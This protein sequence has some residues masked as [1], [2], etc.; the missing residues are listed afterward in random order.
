M[1]NKWLP[2]AFTSTVFLL[3]GC[4]LFLLKKH[5]LEFFLLGE[6]LLV[7]SLVLFILIY[8]RLIQPLHTIKS[9]VNLLKEEDFNTRLSNV[10][11]ESIDGIVSVYNQMAEKLREERINHEE[12]NFFLE[13]LIEASPAGIIIFTL[14]D[15]ILKINPAACNI[16]LTKEEECIGHSL[17]EINSKLAIELSKIDVNQTK[18]I[19]ENGLKRYKTHKAAF[20][21]KGYSRKF[22]LIEEMTKELVKT[23]KQAYEKVIRMM[24]HEVNNSVAAVNSMM[25]VVEEHLTSLNGVNYQMVD[26]LKVSIE[27]NNNMN[28]FMANFATVVKTPKAQKVEFNLLDI[29]KKTIKLFSKE[30]EKKEI[31]IILNDTKTKFNI[32]A[33]PIQFEQVIINILK[34]SMEAIAENGKIKILFITNPKSIIISDNGRGISSEENKNLFTP[35][36]STKKHGQGIGLTLIREILISHEFKFSL[37]TNCSGVTEFRII[38]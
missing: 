28:Q 30:L 37:E 32:E 34:N 29:I 10:G 26:A 15:K 3:F 19:S 31:S 35:F 14:D 2:I 25:Q 5:S 12:K 4:L 11:Q 9:A 23:E 36:Y 24:S 20:I 27:R 33:D 8:N 1:K 18:L 7:L 16:L 6:I 38:F 21:D 13:L 17:N 22:L